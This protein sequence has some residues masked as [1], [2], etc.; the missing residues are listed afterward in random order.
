MKR[1]QILRFNTINI[2]VNE[3]FR[4]ACACYENTKPI[5]WIKEAVDCHSSTDQIRFCN[6]NI[7][8]VE[9][10]SSSEMKAIKYNEMYEIF[11]VGF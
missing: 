4:T 8:F 11:F 10:T 6:K 5:N 1:D 3:L 2:F 9:T 7:E